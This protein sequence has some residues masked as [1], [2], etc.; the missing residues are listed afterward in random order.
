MS[1]QPKNISQ[2][3]ENLELSELKD[4]LKDLKPQLDEIREKVSEEVKKTKGTVESQV[5]ANPWAAIGIAGLVFF[6]IG[7]LLGSKGRG[8]D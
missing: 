7:F 1:D 3:L 8:R 2:A 4:A 5:K 6:L